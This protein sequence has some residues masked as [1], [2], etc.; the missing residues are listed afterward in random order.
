MA[1]KA[2]GRRRSASPSAAASAAERVCLARRR[3]G[4]AGARATERFDKGMAPDC[5]HEGW[6]SKAD[7]TPPGG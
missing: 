3:A 5:L 2:G 1:A 7:D 6:R 4:C